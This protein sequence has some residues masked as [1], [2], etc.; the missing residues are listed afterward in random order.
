[1]IM[2]ERV[3]L[4]D[5]LRSFFQIGANKIRLRRKLAILAGVARA[6]KNGLDPGVLRGLQID[7]GIAHEPGLGEI[8][9]KIVYR[10]LD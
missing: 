7:C 5:Q 8:N 9:A 6:D 3:L 10:P 1:M 2:D 4:H